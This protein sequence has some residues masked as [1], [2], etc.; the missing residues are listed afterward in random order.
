MLVTTCADLISYAFIGFLQWD[1]ASNNWHG[2]NR[3]MELV[4]LGVLRVGCGVYYR[5]G[6]LVP[7]TP[8]RGLLPR[9]P[10]RRQSPA[11]EKATTVATGRR[12]ISTNRFGALRNRASTSIVTTRR[13]SPSSKILSQRLVPPHALYCSLNGIGSFFA[14]RLNVTYNV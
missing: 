9:R 10:Q 6:G 8:G 1:Y 5:L 11:K 7:Y 13:H 2:N 12:C 3:V 14:G 4:D